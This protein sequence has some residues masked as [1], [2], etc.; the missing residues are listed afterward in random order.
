MV[1]GTFELTSK[2]LKRY[3][4]KLRD[5]GNCIIWTGSKDARGYGVVRNKRFDARASILAFYLEHGIIPEGM[6]VCHS[7][8]NPLCCNPAHL[9]AGTHL[10]N[11]QDCIAKGRWKDQKGSA[12]PRSRLTEEQVREILAIKGLSHQQIANRYGIARTAITRILN[13]K[14]WNHVSDTL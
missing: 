13:G 9:W 5:E 11:M 1:A 14:R 10:E 6:L 3:E 7:C 4:S 2:E 12:N 8:D